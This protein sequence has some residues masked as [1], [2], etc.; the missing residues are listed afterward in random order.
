M[1]LRWAMF[2]SIV[3]LHSQCNWPSNMVSN[4]FNKLNESIN[5][6]TSFIINEADSEYNA[7]TRRAGEGSP[8]RLEV[9]SIRLEAKNTAN[10][11]DSL[12]SQ[13]KVLL[14]DTLNMEKLTPEYMSQLATEKCLNEHFLRLHSICVKCIK[15]LNGQ[16]RE[17]GHEIDS[18]MKRETNLASHRGWTIEEFKGVPVFASITLLNRFKSDCQMAELI[19]L[20]EV[21][22][23]LNVTKNTSP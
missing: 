1:K 4:S 22:T 15:G 7:I 17:G 19:T 8:I 13:L 10:Y 21:N 12:Y 6:S 23:S 3:L 2:I 9:D 18:V 14:Q 5:K 16:M 20:K 11:L